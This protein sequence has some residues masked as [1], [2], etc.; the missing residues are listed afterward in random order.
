MVMGVVN[1]TPDS[2]Y[3]GGRYS[4]DR[5]FRHID[6]LVGEGAD[7]L[8]IGGESTRPGSV[9]VPAE[10]QLRRI[11]P[12][13]KHALGYAGVL[14]SLDTTR[15][16]VASEGL[17]WGAHWVN[18]VSCLATAELAKVTAHHRAKLVLMHSRPDMSTMQGFSEYPKTGYDD[19]VA[20]VRRE[21]CR[22]R[23]QALGL[24]M[25]REDILFDPGFGFSKN[26]EQS[27]Q[28]LRR[29]SVFRDLEVPIVVGPSRKSFISA[30]DRSAPQERLGGTIAACLWAATHGASVVRVHD[31]QE[32]R[33]ALDTFAVLDIGAIDG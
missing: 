13:V 26:A 25:A 20:D 8:D 11:E 30:Q 28:L 23:D 24:G 21:W 19:V 2:F 5:V 4:G 29:L 6:K 15:P 14:V 3:D 27:L 9:P 31:V 10:E 17:A 22:A 16:E 32:V 7:V 18:D 1:V 33:Q 12:A